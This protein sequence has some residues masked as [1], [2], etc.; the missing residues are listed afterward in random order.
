MGSRWEDLDLDTL[1]QVAQASHFLVSPP[2]S[3][4]FFK[5][6]SFNMWWALMVM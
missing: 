3:H 2:F 1:A 5:H 6:Y 4:G